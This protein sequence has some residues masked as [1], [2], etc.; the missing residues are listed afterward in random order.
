[1]GQRY[2]QCPILPKHLGIFFS[3]KI[4]HSF[5]RID[6]KLPAILLAHFLARFLRGTITFVP[7]QRMMAKQKTPAPKNADAVR[8]ERIPFERLVFLENNPRTRTPE[9]LQKMAADIAADPTFY[10]NRPTLVNLVDGVYYVYAGDLRAHAAHDVLGWAEVPCNVEADVPPEVQR[11]R[12]IVDNTHREEWDFD[13][14]AEWEFEPDELVEMG[15]W[16]A[17]EGEDG[18]ATIESLAPDYSA[19]NQEIDVD[20]LE[21]N[22]TISLKYTPDEYWQVKEQLSKIAATPERAVWTLLGNE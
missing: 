5:R 19:Q 20:A 4:A 10:E 22:M 16:L 18:E 1:M 9:G 8:L 21:S 3:K 11:R 14:L 15:V 17:D 13:K 7:K 12:A 2:R 6:P